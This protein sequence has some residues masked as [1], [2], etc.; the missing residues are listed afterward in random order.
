MAFAQ[1]R[2]IPLNGNGQ[3]SIGQLLSRYGL[4]GNQ[5]V[6]LAVAEPGRAYQSGSLIAGQQLIA[7]PQLVQQQV[8]LLQTATQIQQAPL[9]LNAPVQPVNVHYKSQ[10]APLNVQHTHIPA[11]APETK[12]SRSEEEPHKIIHEVVRPVIQ[13]VREIIQVNSF[14]T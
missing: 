4:S 8:P 6:Y 9:V 7:A 11:P 10:S 5:Q 12:L 2:L 1:Q 13:E 3:I 14:F